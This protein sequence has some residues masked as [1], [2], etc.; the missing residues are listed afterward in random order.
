M[1][2]DPL[3]DP[4]TGEAGGDDAPPLPDAMSLDDA[5]ALLVREH[6]VAIGADDPILMAVT[7]HQGFVRD[8][9]RLLAGQAK[10][11]DALLAAAGTAYAEAAEHV[12]ESL[13]DKTIKASLEQ[14]LALVGEQ[15]KAMESLRRRMRRHGLYHTLL[16]LLSLAAVAL[17]LA[18]LSN[19]IR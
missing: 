19:I 7:L 10:R 18:I 3:F 5:R 17:A 15:A 8:L 2:G 1:T 16:S 13:K 4:V 12:L 9:D 6:G 11:M 14:S